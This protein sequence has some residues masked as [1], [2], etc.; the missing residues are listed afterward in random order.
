MKY[1]VRIDNLTTLPEKLVRLV[2]DFDEG[3]VADF[4]ATEIPS[5]FYVEYAYT[6]NKTFKL[7]AFV[8]PEIT[9]APVTKTFENAIRVINEYDIVDT[10]LYTTH[11]LVFDPP[12]S[13]CPQ[14]YP[15][16]W[17]IAKNFNKT[18][19][20]IQENLEYLMYKTRY[21]DNNNVEFIGWYGIAGLESA[22]DCG[23][24]NWT[25]SRAKCDFSAA[26]WVMMMSDNVESPFRFCSTWESASCGL[27]SRV[28]RDMH[29]WLWEDAEDVGDFPVKWGEIST[30]ATISSKYYNNNLWYDFTCNF[31]TGPIKVDFDVVSDS[32]VD[33]LAASQILSGSDCSFGARWHVNVT[34]LNTFVNNMP[35]A[36]FND[37]CKFTD[38][39]IRDSVMYTATS[40]QVRACS[41]N[42][43]ATPIQPFI[44]GFDKDVEF[45]DIVAIAP[46]G[47][48]RVVVCDKGN[49][50]IASF[51]FKK[52]NPQKW[53]AGFVLYGIGS[54]LNK[55]KFNTPTDIAVNSQGYIYVNDSGNK[56][57][58]AYTY[59]GEWLRTINLDNAPLSI[60]FD[61]MDKL[62]MLYDVYVS[63]FDVDI[64][65]ESYTYSIITT[66]T[67]L[68]IRANYNR[69]VM[70]ITTRDEVIKHFRTGVEYGVF[71]LQQPCT[72]QYPCMNDIKNIYQDEYRNLYILN[73]DYIVKYVDTM[74]INSKT[75][76][77][78]VSYWGTDEL[79]LHPNE[80]VQNWVYN[81][82]FHRLWDNIELFRCS[83]KYSYSNL[84]S[85]YTEPV[86]SKEE[87]YIG[88]NEIVT[89]SVINRCLRSLWS[90]LLTLYKYFDSTCK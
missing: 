76:A 54:E 26:T 3:N 71:D 15:N 87:I 25:W 57:L 37:N 1:P 32:M 46:G 53:G 77:L 83:L 22:L 86:Y 40:T 9:T 64:P 84:C 23:A 33:L 60:A 12:H 49:N 14:I 21:Y 29:N 81:R 78:P 28:Y 44:K 63:V 52:T 62:H 31:F 56:C 50:G 61:S 82:V 48:D 4:K 13:T 88:Q 10:N 20:S 24:G 85:V 75:N 90:N 35:S 58:K 41:T 73:N 55:Y 66:H 2:V 67:P 79:C 11:N 7:S 17:V 72:V 36:V 68:R 16:E 80:Y 70:Y 51:V 69:E 30:T 43:V 74:Y 59:R 39:F 65:A 19:L 6:G 45:S 8:P 47:K 42:L 18:I 27:P 38:M 5:S 34:E 89:S